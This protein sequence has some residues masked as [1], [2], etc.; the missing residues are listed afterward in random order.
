MPLPPGPPGPSALVTAQF[1]HRPLAALT[2]WER[3]YGEA[4]TVRLTGFG[5]G[6]YVADPGAVKELFTGDQSDLLAGEAKSFLTPILGEHSVLVLDGPR[7]LR[8]RRLLLPPFQGSRVAVF[9]EVI[10]DVAEREVA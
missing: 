10:R 5:P 8:Q 2:R 4:F 6:V 1:V 9:R 3:R 7:H